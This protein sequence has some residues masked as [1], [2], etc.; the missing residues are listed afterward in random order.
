MHEPN[1]TLLLAKAESKITPPVEVDLYGR[2]ADGDFVG[3]EHGRHAPG[4]L[5]SCSY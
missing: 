1:A 5:A 2:D 3:G 4:G